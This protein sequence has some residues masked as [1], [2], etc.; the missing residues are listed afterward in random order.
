MVTLGDVDG[1]GTLDVVVA[2]MTNRDDR[3]RDAETE[4]AYGGGGGL[5]VLSAETGLPLPNFPVELHNR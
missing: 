4:E 3:D 1:D 5:W 2:A